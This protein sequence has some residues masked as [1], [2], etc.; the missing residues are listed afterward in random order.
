MKILDI[1]ASHGECSLL[2]TAVESTKDVKR[3]DL[4]IPTKIEKKYNKYMT[5]VDSINKSAKEIPSLTLK[6]V[7]ALGPTLLDKIIGEAINSGCGGL[8]HM[9]VTTVVVSNV[10]SSETRIDADGPTIV[11]LCATLMV[12]ITLES[13]HAEVIESRNP[14]VKAAHLL[15][16]HFAHYKNTFTT[17]KNMP[18]LDGAGIATK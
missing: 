6:A 13:S 3:P 18:N 15:M 16:T 2:T 12:H 14:G 1:T 5:D 10:D 9:V 8:D 11:D 7:P 17:T 4:C